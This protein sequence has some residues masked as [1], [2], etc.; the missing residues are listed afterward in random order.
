[1]AF[2]IYEGVSLFAVAGAAAF[3]F[4]KQKGKPRGRKRSLSF[5]SFNMIAGS[6]PCE[7]N[8]C[9]PIVSN[10]LFFEKLPEMALLRKAVAQ[11]GVSH[12]CLCVTRVPSP[13][14]SW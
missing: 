13:C 12:I 10:L 3:L 2:P 14:A 5:S 1:M 8:V 11:V 6:F 4:F 7:T 9:P